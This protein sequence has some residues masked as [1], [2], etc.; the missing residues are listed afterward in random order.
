[1]DAELEPQPGEIPLSV[2]ADILDSTERS[3]MAMAARVPGFPPARM[4]RVACNVL[5][6]H[7]DGAAIREWREN[8]GGPRE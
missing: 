2:A 7:F 3:V 5:R 6:A 1:V 4:R 8:G